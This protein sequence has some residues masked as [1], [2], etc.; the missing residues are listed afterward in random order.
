MLAGDGAADRHAQL[1]DLAA[2]GFGA[3][4]FAAAPL[5]VELLRRQESDDRP[6]Q[7]IA[8]YLGPLHGV[9]DVLDG[10]DRRP[11]GRAFNVEPD[12]G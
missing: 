8:V 11:A 7:G 5:A 4:Q 3:L 9:A 1:Q 2:D 12:C 6:A 10:E